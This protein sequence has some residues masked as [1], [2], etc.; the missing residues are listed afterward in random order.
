[1]TERPKSW[2]ELD[3]RMA[4]Q[5]ERFLDP[6]IELPSTLFHHAR[7]HGYQLREVAVL[8][9]G[10]SAPSP[11]SLSDDSKGTRFLIGRLLTLLMVVGSMI[12]LWPLR[13]R[14][15]RLLEHPAFWLAAVAL[16]GFL[17]APMPVAIALLVVALSM[18]LLAVPHRSR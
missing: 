1:M 9:S 3:R 17:V 16:C 6:K 10:G 18:P 2:R 13:T 8:D 14:G 4:L 15:R 7:W 12:I 5:V 11:P